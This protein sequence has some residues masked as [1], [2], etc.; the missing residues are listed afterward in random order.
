MFSKHIEKL[1]E[2][3]VASQATAVAKAAALAEA[4]T[5]AKAAAAQRAADFVALARR[6]GVSMEEIKA[7]AKL[8]RLPSAAYAALQASAPAGTELKAF[9]YEEEAIRQLLAEQKM[10]I[11]RLKSETVEVGSD[12]DDDAVVVVPP[13]QVS[14]GA[15]AAAAAAAR[16]PPPRSCNY[17]FTCNNYAQVELDHLASLECKYI[18]YGKEVGESGTPH[19][20]GQVCF[21][22]QRTFNVVKGLLGYRFHVEVTKNVHQSIAYCKKDGDFIERGTMPMSAAAKG[23]LGG[24]SGHLGGEH[25]HLGAS[26]GVKGGAAEKKRWADALALVKEGRMDEVDAQIQLVHARSCEFVY[27]KALR[28]RPLPDYVPFS[29]V[30]LYGGTGVG[31]SRVARSLFPDHY[32]KMANKWWDGYSS[33]G[34]V[35]MDDVDPTSMGHLAHFIKTWTDHY[36]FPCEV[37]GGAVRCRPK[38]FVF[39]SNYTLREC[40]P[41]AQDYLALERRFD[42][43]EVFANP[44]DGAE[45]LVAKRVAGAG[46]G[47]AIAMSKTAIWAR[48]FNPVPQ[49]IDA[50]QLERTDTP[51]PGANVTGTAMEVLSA[52]AEVQ[53]IA[54][55]NEAASTLHALSGASARPSS[56]YRSRGDSQ[57]NVDGDYDDGDEDDEPTAVLAE[58]EEEEDGGET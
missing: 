57:E 48:N 51:F 2:N 50:A 11:K 21:A 33:Q 15:Q 34:T 25:G 1:E 30:W 46:G 26:H 13:A 23:A 8:V 49:V 53:Q 29:N 56:D 16:P 19:L 43:Y 54:A 58:E 5:A 4:A 6:R 7:R 17:A 9:Y 41:N 22:T 35:I 3:K 12:S 38:S 27:T 52:A 40:F 55:L 32:I 45:P 31:K 47:E 14:P 10:R 44:E 39:T 42:V 36:P 20:Q 28:A 24:S 37:K 18:V